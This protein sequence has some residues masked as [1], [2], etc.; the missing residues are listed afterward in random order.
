MNKLTI[1]VPEKRNIDIKTG[2]LDDACAR[3]N[4]GRNSMRRVAE[5]AG[6]VVRIGRSY[7]V[8]FDKV[9]SYMDALAE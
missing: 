4:L 9:D 3:Y 2:K 5:D 7:L 1:R 8:N 6:A